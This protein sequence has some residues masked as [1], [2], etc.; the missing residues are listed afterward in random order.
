M[1]DPVGIQV[2]GEV[3]RWRNA[4][5]GT[6]AI[7]LRLNRRLHQLAGAGVVVITNP[8]HT[9]AISRV[10]KDLSR[11]FADL[12]ASAGDDAV[13]YWASAHHLAEAESIFARLG[14]NPTY[15]DIL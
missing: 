15:A 14:P 13:L 6:D 3:R 9:E 2:G 8:H 5:A 11:E 12:L 4:S 10:V 1:S 7:L